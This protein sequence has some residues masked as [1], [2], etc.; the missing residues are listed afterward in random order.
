M[1][2]LDWIYS[3][4]EST[5]GL[6]L[7]KKAKILFLGLDNAG[8]TTL[9]NRLK[10][11]SLKTPMPT[12]HPSMEELIIGKITFQTFD[13]GGHLQARKVWREYFPQ[14]DAIIFLID[15]A[16]TERF[17]ESKAELDGLLKNED[18]STVPVLILG[19]KIDLG[20]AVS[21]FQ[22]REYFGLTA[23][24][25][26]KEQSSLKGQEIRPLELF[27]CSIVFGQ[28]YKEGFAWLSQYIK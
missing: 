26:G 12:V 6:K 7:R 22:I 4:L 18:L 24:T 23:T 8:K 21:E 27:M 13:L 17:T 10:T 15:S 1:F 14:V 20:S 11:G 9:L 3:F 16:D 5:L 28:G 25:S 2:I 19:N